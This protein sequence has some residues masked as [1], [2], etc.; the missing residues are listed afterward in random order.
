MTNVLS[1]DADDSVNVNGTSLQGTIKATYLELSEVFR[2]PTYTDADPYEKVNAEWAVEAKTLSSW[3]DDE[4]DAESSVFTIYNW[5]MGYIPTEEYDWHIGGND[6]GAVEI[7]ETIL[8][9]NLS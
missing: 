6:F 1:F 4:E 2:Q 5:K 7:A 8:K 3:A 9:D